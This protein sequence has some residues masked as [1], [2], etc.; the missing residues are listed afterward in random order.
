MGTYAL[1]QFEYGYSGTFY[2]Y[3]INGLTT[4]YDLDGNVLNLTGE[5]GYYIIDPNPPLP[6]WAS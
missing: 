6:T 2:Q 5:Y 3:N 4:F 1:C